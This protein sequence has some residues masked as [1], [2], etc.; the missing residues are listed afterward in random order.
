MPAGYALGS[1]G[2]P[3]S[4]ETAS[5]TSDG[6]LPRHRPE[7]S[8]RLAVLTL[9]TRTA[10]RC[11]ACLCLFGAWVSA[12]G[13]IPVHQTPRQSMP[14]EH[15]RTSRSG[16]PVAHGTTLFQGRSVAYQVVDGLAIYD[17]DIVLGPANEV[18]AAP[19]D[20]ASQKSTSIP[21]LKRRDASAVEGENRLWPDGRIPYVIDPS[22]VDER[23]DLDRA[24]NLWNSE[25]VI[26][27]VP[28]TTER[29]YVRFTAER[30]GCRANVG[31]VGGQQETTIGN[32][33]FFGIV[34]EIG[35]NVG[36]YHPH[37]RVDRDQYIMFEP[38]A[39]YGTASTPAS[40]PFDYRSNMHWPYG[41]FETIPPGMPYASYLSPGD[42]DGVARLYGKPPTA[43]TISTNPAGLEVIVD[44]ER[45]RAPATFQWAAGT[46]HVLEVPLEP[47]QPE[48]G[49]R[50]PWWWIAKRD[51][52]YLFGRW[53]DGG[54]RRHTVTADPGTTW[55][56]ASFVEIGKPVVQLVAFRNSEW[57]E[58]VGEAVV[59]VMPEVGEVRA[60][61]ESP[62]GYSLRQTPTT[63][64]ARPAPGSSYRVGTWYHGWDRAFLS[65]SARQVVKFW[66]TDSVVPYFSKGPFLSI[67]SNEP[68][69]PAYLRWTSRNRGYDLWTPVKLDPNIF[70]TDAVLELAA[71]ETFDRQ[72]TR[73]RFENWGDGG[74]DER[75]ELGSGDPATAYWARSRRL[76]F[77]SAGGAIQLNYSKKHLLS[78]L[79]FPRWYGRSVRISPQSDDG[80]YDSG[81]SVQVTASPSRQFLRWEGDVSGTDP[82]AIVVMDRPKTVLAVFSS[83]S[84]NAGQTVPQLLAYP[85]AFTFVTHEGTGG[86]PQVVQITNETNDPLSF[87]VTSSRDWVSVEP[88]DGT[89][90][91]L[92]TQEISITASS[93][94]LRSGARSAE[95]SIV[96]ARPESASAGNR[97]QRIPV[98]HVTLP[99]E[100]Q[101][102]KLTGGSSITLTQFWDGQWR[103]GNQTVESGYRHLADGKEYVLKQVGGRWK[104]RTG[105]ASVVLGASGQSA[106]VEV[107]ADNTAY[108]DGQL[109]A[110]GR[111]VPVTAAN[112]DTYVVTKASNGAIVATYVRRSQ[113][114]LMA[115][116]TEI[117]LTKE[118]E[119]QGADK[120]RAGPN[121]VRIDRPIVHAGKEYFVELVGSHWRPA[122]RLVRTVVGNSDL[123]VGTPALEA[124]L[125]LPVAVAVDAA[126]NVLVADTNS[127]L[128][129]RIDATGMIT[130]VAGTGWSGYSGDGGP[131]VEANLGYPRA[132]DVDVRG[133]VYVAS[134][135]RVRKIDAAGTITTVAG[136]GEPGYSGDGGPATKARLASWF[137]IAVDSKGNVYVAD[138]DNNR[139]RRIRATGKITTV[140]GTGE[141]GHGGDG[142]PAIEASVGYPRAIDVD[143][144]GN[145]YVAS[146]GRV[147]K[148]DAAGMITTVA[149][150]GGP[151]ATEEISSIYGIDL[152]A[153]GNIFIADSLYESVMKIDVSG[154]VTTLAQRP[155]I[156]APS[157]VA[158]DAAGN[159]YTAEYRED[160]LQRIDAAGMVHAFAGTGG[161]KDPD[162]GG[163]TSSIDHRLKDPTDV[164]V[165]LA[166]EV[167]FVDRGRIWKLDS[168][169]G[170][171]SV[172]A[173][174]GSYGYGGD[175]GPASEAQL[176]YVTGIAADGSGNVYITSYNHVVRKID[177][178]GTI[179]TVAGTG[180]YGFS[181]DGGPATAAQ[182]HGPSSVAL[183]GLGNLYVVDPGNRRIRKIDPAGTIATLAATTREF[184]PLGMAADSSGTVYVHTSRDLHRI[185]ASGTI[186]V[187]HRSGNRIHA[188][189]IDDADDIILGWEDRIVKLDARTLE[190]FV[191]AGAGDGNFKGNRIPARSALLSVASQGIAVDSDGRVWFADAENRRIRVVE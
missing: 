163:A 99:T 14:G 102:V 188:I 147:R 21:W 110:P 43:T 64:E 157:D 39:D 7:N 118:R 88:A 25:T 87:Q 29:D 28:R 2:Q 120:W 73:F 81:T 144:W 48:G 83:G 139:V 47:Q 23:E 107:F 119:G 90:H 34:H 54:S 62:D 131:A 60:D 183:D 106:V 127:H 100:S 185:D 94:D 152:D 91:S 1:L 70:G 151:A 12:I 45:V 33:A 168:A 98:H 160:R 167:F 154:E 32:C 105:D 116:G 142:G 92:E 24:I 61:Q 85:R 44:G 35:H 177:A 36:L 122:E 55:Y 156:G 52:R 145:V 115:D 180:T 51:E 109:V 104:Q 63:L 132:V 164:A 159:V 40:G 5:P 182:L 68:T 49:S 124:S 186:S 176:G 150:R 46:T 143:V 82:Q 59:S 184:A 169:A 166:G 146:Q 165:G 4:D 77:P 10:A 125:N 173:G 22:V 155:T 57:V 8:L 20:N 187:I 121:R 137:D 175:G 16:A 103:I 149:G 191:I 75:I 84:G 3:R 96:A 134:Q 41:Y 113:T 181:G 138:P 114:V 171:V 79:V 93:A 97:R 31:R 128:V 126:G 80:Y 162:G 189:A 140:A 130:T 129:R 136:T 174:T 178:T 108:L 78:A 158:V 148:I 42:I 9:P 179:S 30:R 53:T 89:L 72:G 170:Q 50:L 37:N 141:S 71:R 133:N 101:D 19:Q 27:L 11:L 13:Q 58:S 86:D 15:L 172:F 66:R 17:G 111:R 153:V 65:A 69:V 161:W 6:H 190:G 135:R 117:T 123:P 26:T 18:A 76:E 74:A 95:I 67:E 56:Q 112:G 38:G